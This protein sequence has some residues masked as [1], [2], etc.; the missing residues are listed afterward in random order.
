MV[1]TKDSQL[2]WVESIG[3]K[4]ALTIVCTAA[5]CWPKCPKIQWKCGRAVALTA[6]GFPLFGEIVSIYTANCDRGAVRRRK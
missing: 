1:A 6:I 2:V 4:R 3:L 5:S